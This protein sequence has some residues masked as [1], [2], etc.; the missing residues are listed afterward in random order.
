VA[1]WRF[2]WYDET[3]AEWRS[4]SGRLEQIDDTLNGPEEA[5]FYIANTEE[6]R[7][8]IAEDRPARISFDGNIIFTGVLSGAVYSSTRIRC[9]VYNSCY[10]VM[11]RRKI[12]GTYLETPAD[13]ILGDICAAA[14]VTAG[15]CPD[16][17]VS[18]RFDDAYCFD[19]AMFLREVL[20][21]D[22]WAVDDVFFIADKGSEKSVSHFR[23]QSRGVDRS[24][25]R[26]KVIVK[27]VDSDGNA[28]EGSAG[29][30]VNVA[31]YREKKA[32]DV[33]TLTLL[34]EQKL[35][36][37]NTDS[38]GAPLEVVISEA[39]L[40]YSGDTLTLDVPEFSLSG[41]FRIK[42]VTK[43]T[44]KAT[45]ELDRLQGGLDALVSSI[46]DV[47]KKYEELGISAVPTVEKEPLTLNLQ[48]LFSL[49][50]LNEGSGTTA[51]DVM[52]GSDGAIVNGYWVEGWTRYLN[53]DGDGYVDCG[54]SFN[55][56]GSDKFAV[57]GWV[58]P[59]N[60][61]SDGNYILYKSGQFL[62]QLYGTG[63][64]PRFG[65]YVGGGWHYVTADS[66]VD[67][68]G[69]VFVMGVYTGSELRLYVDGE[70]AKSATLTGNVDASTEK[71]YIGSK[72]GS[73][74]FE[75]AM[76]EVMLWTR[77]LDDA[78][79]EE[80]YYYPLLRLV[81]TG[82]VPSGGGGGG[83]E[84]EPPLAYVYVNFEDGISYASEQIAVADALVP[85][86]QE[87]TRT[88]GVVIKNP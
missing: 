65:V 20:N 60:V 73:G 8:I 10:E 70:L 46:T 68:Y 51:V 37:L 63:N 42:R 31:V 44:A 16:T 53:F 34:A 82:S 19:A 47:Y 22:Y 74:G 29:A 71:V 83:G 40:L 64:K 66:G 45:V 32:T 39:A 21:S 61:F 78:E 87:F 12:S 72:A 50:H 5:S 48:G 25:R 4:F 27:G 2:E 58:S 75:G 23:V 59:E 36:E 26:D 1:K 41:T 76:A 17:A 85:D 11:K 80:L 14:G 9:I 52:G 54:S 18:V 33:A 3:A 57:G 28:I 81:K 77:A 13:E 88:E 24:K 35:A 6:N 30:G 84:E 38:T 86:L 79:V 69:R 62:L 67:L 7:A 49:Y 56:G 55:V 43:Y 15:D